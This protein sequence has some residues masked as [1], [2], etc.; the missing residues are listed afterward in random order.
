MQDYENV[1]LFLGQGP[2][3]FG[4]LAKGL[5]GMFYIRDPKDSLYQQPQ[6]VPNIYR[7][8]NPKSINSYD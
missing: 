3:L 1:T 6:D 4:Q 8:V 5:G 7:N 2:T